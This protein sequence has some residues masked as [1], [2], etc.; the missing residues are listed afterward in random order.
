MLFRSIKPDNSMILYPLPDTVYNINGEFFHKAVVMDDNLD[1]PQ[2]PD[3]FHM[4]VVWRALMLYGAFDAADEKYS[5]GQNEYKTMLL[6]LESD[7]LQRVRW[8]DPLA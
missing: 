2:F 3:Q 6:A 7:Q 5:H 8:G 4:I 1:E